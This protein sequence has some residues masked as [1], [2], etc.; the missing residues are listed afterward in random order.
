MTQLNCAA[1]DVSS[2]TRLLGGASALLSQNSYSVARACPPPIP[3]MSNLLERGRGARL[4]NIHAVGPGD[5]CGA[6]AG[7]IGI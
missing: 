7:I 6:Y 3:T 5:Q 4:M 2:I 1:G